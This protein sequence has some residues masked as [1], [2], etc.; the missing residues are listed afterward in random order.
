VPIYTNGEIQ[1]SYEVEGNGFPI[2]LIA[3]G[4]M[5]SEN[6]LWANA[7]WNPRQELAT[8]YQLIGMDQRNAGSSSAPITGSDSWEEYTYDQLGLLDAIGVDRCHVIGM[9]IGGPYIAGLLKSNPGRFA[10]AVIFQ[11]VGVDNNR[12]AFYDMFDAWASDLINE[13]QGPQLEAME[14][15]RGNMWDKEFLLTVT[16]DDVK[17]FKNPILLFMGDDLYHPQVTSRK[18]AAL[19]P[20]VTLVENWKTPETLEKTDTTIRSFLAL[21]S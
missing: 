17:K 3:P 10:S 12:Q 13:E 7:P 11:P 21:H 4:G 2:L 5:R 8:E 9:C 16:E 1:I 19:A 15:F 6:A 18:I 20:N 14:Q